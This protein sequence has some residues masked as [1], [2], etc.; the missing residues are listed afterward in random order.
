MGSKMREYVEKVLH[1]LD[2]GSRAPLFAEL[3]GS[4]DEAYRTIIARP[5]S[6]RLIFA[7][8]M[9]ICHKSFL[10]AATLIAQQQPEDAGGITRRAAEC[11]RVALAIRL[12][13]ANADHWL[14]YQERYDR[15]LKRRQGEK[16]KY[17]TVKFADMTNEP[18]AQELDRWLGI[19]SD[20]LVHFT[21][22]F[23][24]SLAWEEHVEPS[25]NGKIFLNY[26]HTDQREIERSVLDLAAV[27]GTILKTFD[28]C[29]DGGI[30]ADAQKLAAVNEFWATA[31]RLNGDYGR[32]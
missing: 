30:S 27:H 23:Y 8:F 16:P 17:F 21:P 10:S 28:R 15:W 32:R 13:D 25:C 26:F 2:G 24:D 6:G 18:L 9:L 20:A 12:N 19:L 31:R 3:I 4:L 1:N 11:A 7:R 14:S 29:F 22:E 5:P